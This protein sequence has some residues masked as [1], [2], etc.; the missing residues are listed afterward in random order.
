MWI[1]AAEFRVKFVSLSTDATLIA[2][3]VTFRST[4]LSSLLPQLAI[5]HHIFVCYVANGLCF[6]KEAAEIVARCVQTAELLV[7]VRQAPLCT[8]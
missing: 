4:S 3:L 1:C 6:I 2:F 7:S 8:E 5:S